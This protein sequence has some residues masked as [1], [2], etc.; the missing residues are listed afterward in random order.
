[1]EQ[2]KQNK[3]FLKKGMSR[4]VQFRLVD[5]TLFYEMVNPLGNNFD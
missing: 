4:K 1:L 5:L 2:E 3:V